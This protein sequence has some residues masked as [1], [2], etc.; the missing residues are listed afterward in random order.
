MMTL[1]RDE[2]E[3][4]LALR[5]A[6]GFQFRGQW[7]CFFPEGQLYSLHVGGASQKERRD[8]QGNDLR[9]Q[10]NHP[11]K[12][13]MAGGEEFKRCLVDRTDRTTL[14]IG[15]AGERIL[16]KLREKQGYIRIHIQASQV[17]LVVKNPPAHAGDIRHVG[18]IPGSERSP[19][20]GHDKPL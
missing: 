3:F 8:K 7:L 15:R 1:P 10:C 17:V 5:G 19:G 4:V 18:S 13:L 6:R 11:G 12:D 2:M 9:A 20:G 16:Q 14:L